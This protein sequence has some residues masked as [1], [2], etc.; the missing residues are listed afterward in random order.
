MDVGF[1]DAYVTVL[2]SGLVNLALGVIVGF[3]VGAATQSV[4]AVNVAAFLMLPVN[5][6]TQ[7]GFVS[8]RSSYPLAGRS[9]CLSP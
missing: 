9:W 8:T 2:L 3:A 1:G 4:D 5:L 6:L 7:S